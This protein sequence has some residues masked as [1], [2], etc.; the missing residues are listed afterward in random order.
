MKT[1]PTPREL[2]LAIVALALLPLLAEAALRIAHVEFPGQL[3]IADHELGWA[4]RPNAEALVTEEARQHVRTNSHGF[5]DEERSYRKPDGTF[6]IAVLGNSWTEALQVPLDKTFCSVLQHRLNGSPCFT[7]RNVEVLNFGV[8][9]Y[10]TAQ[11]LLTLDHEVRN[12]HPDLV[13]A[14]FYAARD[15]ANNVRE[16]NNAS[17]PAQSPY[18]V[19]RGDR[20]ALDRSFQSLPSLQRQQI[21]LQ[22]ARMFASS[23]FRVLAAVDALVQSGRAELANLLARPQMHSATDDLEFATLKAPSQP[24]VETAW[25][26]TE[27]L[28]VRMR[29]VSHDMGADFRIVTL[30]TR[31]QV[32]PDAGLRR[33]FMQSL[34][35]NDLSYA[36]AR[37][38]ALGKQQS[39]SVTVLAPALSA[40]AE[41]HHQYLNGFDAASYGKGHW[42]ELGHLLA[43]EAIAHDLCSTESNVAVTKVGPRDYQRQSEAR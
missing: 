39:I 8:S 13:I 5:R 6:R 29:D 42:N 21:Q 24:E 30:A 16:L 7:G 9:G 11:E 22:K 40:Y 27:A 32:I 36:D 25:R 31:P 18:F 41:A 3:Y 37:I 17:D 4:L 12:Y 43:A 33:A 35:V 34:G 23:H 1:P 20:L 38:M 10:S 19:L 14:T 2:L 26:V 15:V 28:L